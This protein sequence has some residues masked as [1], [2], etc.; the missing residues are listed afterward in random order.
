MG[1]NRR[2]RRDAVFDSIPEYRKQRLIAD[3]LVAFAQTQAIS[4]PRAV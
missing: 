1:H 2:I 3:P 4:R